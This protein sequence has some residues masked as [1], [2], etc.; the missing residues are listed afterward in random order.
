MLTDSPIRACRLCEECDSL[1]DHQDKIKVLSLTH[2]NLQKVLAELEDIVVLP[3]RADMVLG[4]LEDPVNILPAFEALTVLE[5]T[6]ENA[7][8][9]WNRCER[10][11]AIAE[12]LASARVEAPP[13]AVV[14]LP[15]SG[16]L[17][18]HSGGP[19]PW[20]SPHCLAL[21]RKHRLAMTGKPRPL[22]C[23]DQECQGCQARL[24]PHVQVPG[25]RE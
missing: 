11:C 23:H 24:Q 1:I 17:C 15:H 14:I 9:A 12:I 20:L 6:A 4:L 18:D 19:V 16:H 13:S 22:S 2:A 21:V 8:Q 5:G 7:K 3:S 25:A 10:A